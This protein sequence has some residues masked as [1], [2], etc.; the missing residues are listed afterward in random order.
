M[1]KLWNMIHAQRLEQ[2][3]DRELRYHLERRIADLQAS[4]LSEPEAH[5]QAAL[6]FGGVTQVQEEVRD[7][8]VWRWLRDLLRDLRFSR[9]VLTARAPRFANR[10]LDRDPLRMNQ[11]PA[12]LHPRFV[13]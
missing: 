7:A 4:G 1:R 8:W 5:R 2:D 13:G 9:R 12:P 10:P 3:L 6:E 11:N